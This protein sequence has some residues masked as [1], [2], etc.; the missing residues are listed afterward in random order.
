MRLSTSKS[1]ADFKRLGSNKHSCGRQ[2][3]NNERR[4]NI[5]RD[6]RGVKP[7]NLCVF[8]FSHIK[9][10][11]GLVMR[12]S[13][14]WSHAGFKRLGHNKHSCGRQPVNDERRSNISRDTIGVKPT[15]LRVF[16][17]ATLKVILDL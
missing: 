1:H 11:F 2:P 3:V 6:T 16:V 14:S 10:C 7:N 15:S 13:T 17:S 5:E 4:S 12:L 8:F 9:G